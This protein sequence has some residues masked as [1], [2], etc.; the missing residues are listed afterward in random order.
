MWLVCLQAA[1]T[2]GRAQ[3]SSGSLQAVI[4]AAGPGD[5]ISVPAGTYQGPIL[6]K[7]DV[8]LVGEGADVTTIDGMGA[9]VVVQGGRNAIVLG[10]TIR[11]GRTAISGQENCL[12]VF[13]CRLCDFKAE[14]LAVSRGCAVIAN[15]L[16]EG[17]P[18]STTGVVCLASNP[19]LSGNVVVSNAVGVDVMLRS[20]PSLMNNIFVANGI[21]VR[22]ASES[23]AFLS[24]NLYDRNGQDVAGQPRGASDRVEAVTLAGGV[25]H[26]GASLESYRKLIDLVLADKL[27]QHPV[28]VYELGK[29]PGEFGMTVLHPWAT[30]AVAAS[31]G[32]TVVARHEAFDRVTDNTLRS[33]LIRQILPTLVVANPEITAVASER[34]ALNCVFVHPQSYSR[35]EK[36]QLVFRRL[37]NLT[38]VQ[39]I[40]PA[41]Y[42]ASSVNLPS[43]TVQ[44]HGSQVVKITRVG[45]K[46]IEVVMDPVSP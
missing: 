33:E 35:N 10:F 4:N 44:E 45:P 30:F 31:A 28:V 20:S 2:G 40:V 32:D 18:L 16:I 12:G 9:A 39:I 21:A 17:N 38:R 37:T 6:L 11:N 5:V 29:D 26:R 8:A 19:Y 46:Q 34:Y 22:V 36:G 27:S 43:T 3:T 24:G 42:A 14:A 15:N 25:P 13:E 41:G 7:E 23:Q 1:V